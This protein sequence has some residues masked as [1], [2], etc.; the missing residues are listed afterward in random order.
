[1]SSV[2]LHKVLRLL[3]RHTLDVRHL[4]AELDAVELVGVLQQFWPEGGC[5]ELGRGGQLVDHVSYG[6]AMLGV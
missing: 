4:V 5:D 1:M 2:I 3:L 6:F